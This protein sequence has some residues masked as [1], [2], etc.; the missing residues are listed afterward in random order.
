MTRCIDENG[1]KYVKSYK[2]YLKE[3]PPRT[4]HIDIDLEGSVTRFPFRGTFTCR[5]P[6][7]QDYILADKKRAALNG[8]VSD[9]ELDHSVAKTTQMLAYLSV[10]IEESPSWWK[11]DLKNGADCLDL[12][13]IL[14][15][16]DKVKAFEKNWKAQ[17]WGIEKGE[18]DAGKGE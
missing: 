3:L 15:L 18:K 14:I 9:D 1:G 8:G 2:D 6:N 10:V 11:E 16:Y 4:G 7:I 17:V 5:V 13:L 12:N